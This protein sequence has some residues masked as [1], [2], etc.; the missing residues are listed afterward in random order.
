MH[1]GL[2][3]HAKTTNFLLI[4]LLDFRFENKINMRQKVNVCSGMNNF[5]LAQLQDFFNIQFENRSFLTVVVD[6]G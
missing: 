2:F 5:V 3:L 1:N 6:A 4:L